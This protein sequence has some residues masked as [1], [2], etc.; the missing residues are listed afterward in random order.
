[1]FKTEG[2]RITTG[3]RVECEIPNNKSKSLLTAVSLKP[4]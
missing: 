3:K 2:H 4:T 1:M